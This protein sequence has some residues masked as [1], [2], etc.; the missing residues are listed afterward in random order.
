MEQLLRSEKAKRVRAIE[1]IVE[2]PDFS[3]GDLDKLDYE[4]INA[5]SNK[6]GEAGFD[7]R[8]FLDFNENGDEGSEEDEVIR[9][10]R[11]HSNLSEAQAATQPLQ[12]IPE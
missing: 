9:R 2:K 5:I 4:D 10:F 11:N 8:D 6:H 7:P 12:A 1:S 3:F